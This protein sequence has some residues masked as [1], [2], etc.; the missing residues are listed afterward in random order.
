[1]VPGNDPDRGCKI[2]LILYNENKGVSCLYW[3]LLLSATVSE[4]SSGAWNVAAT[5]GVAAE[6]APA[7]AQESEG[8]LLPCLQL[9]WVCM[10]PWLSRGFGADKSLCT[11]W[12][13]WGLFY[14]R[15]W[16]LVFSP[17]S[18]ENATGGPFSSGKLVLGRDY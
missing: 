2:T 7:R 10:A 4:T 17:P 5:P 9:T 18:F 6:P 3:V 8:S 16:H 14:R 1:M 12:P 11:P 15:Q 13:W